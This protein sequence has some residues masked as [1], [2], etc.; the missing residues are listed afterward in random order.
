MSPHLLETGDGSLTDWLFRSRVTGR[1][2]VGQA[3]NVTA[4]LWVGAA[5][6]AAIA[7]TPTARVAL[8]R[9]SAVALSVWA[10]DELLRGVNPFR[11]MLGGAVLA[12]QLAVA[13][14]RCRRAAAA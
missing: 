11:R 12:A 4:V 7:P 2:V 3:P 13:A 10:A 14:Q 1:V 6:A 9:V 5:A 8:K